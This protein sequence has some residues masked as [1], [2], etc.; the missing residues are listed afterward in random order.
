MDTVLEVRGGL[1]DMEKGVGGI[2]WDIEGTDPNILYAS[3]SLALIM[4]HYL[5]K[6][7]PKLWSL[8]F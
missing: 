5:E 6:L 4:K 2:E 8:L 7:Q 3:F 1:E